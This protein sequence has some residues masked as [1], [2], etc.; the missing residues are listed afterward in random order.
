MSLEEEFSGYSNNQAYDAVF[1]TRMMLRDPEHK[2][3]VLGNTQREDFLPVL[4]SVLEQLPPQPHLF[5]VGAG[6]G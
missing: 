5:D 1:A 2:D 4:H 6:A 3:R